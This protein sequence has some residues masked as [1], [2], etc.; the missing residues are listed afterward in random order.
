MATLRRLD[1]DDAEIELD[2]SVVRLGRSPE[3]E[4][5]VDVTEVSRAHARI[6]RESG[7][8]RVVDLD[9]TN[10]TFVDLGELRPWQPH[11]L[12]NGSVIDLG[13]V[14]QFRFST[15]ADDDLEPPRT[16]RRAVTKQV[17][18]TPTEA[19]VLE[20]LFM[21]YDRGRSAPRLATV[22]EIAEA[23][24]TSTAAV[25]NALS[26]LYDKFELIDPAQRNKEAL[27]IRAQEWRATQRRS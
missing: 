27:A 4:I 22:K 9:S 10:G 3:N 7:V 25:K 8:W 6:E 11:E 21:H 13:G 15:G 5:V 23:R 16:Q 14:V 17:R 24:T 1:T 2:A 12:R 19:E 18:L 20:L 26:Q